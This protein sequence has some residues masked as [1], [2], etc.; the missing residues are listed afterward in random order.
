M[1]F[2]LL[3]GLTVTGCGLMSGLFFTFS[4]SVMKALGQLPASQGIAAMQS[5]NRTIVNPLFLSVFMG[6]A[7]LCLF[8][9]IN[10]ITQWFVSN[11]IW[12]I[13]GGVFYLAGTFLVTVIFNVPWNDEL[14]EAEADDPRYEVLWT[15]YLSKWTVWNH[16]RTIGAIGS[17]IFF[18]IALYKSFYLL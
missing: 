9:I 1:M 11:S 3:V 6:T 4:N 13:T 15:E 18:M 8:L 10:A 5:I 17:T 14:A 12:M 2:L 7:G 16:V